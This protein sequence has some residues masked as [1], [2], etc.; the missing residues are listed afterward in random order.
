MEYAT[1]W[2]LGAL[3]PLYIAIF[4]SSFA[5]LAWIIPSLGVGSFAGRVSGAFPRRGMAGLCLFMALLLAA[6]WASLIARAEGG[7]QG[8]LLGQT[9]LVI[10]AY[11]L[12]LIVPL[13]VL[14]GVAALR[15]SGL[16]YFLCSVMVVKAAL[17]ASAIAAMLISAWMV[18]GKLE[19][20]PFLVF[21]LAA[22]ASVYLGVKMYSSVDP[23]EA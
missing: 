15:R 11:D 4:A 13:L 2:A 6:M 23:A 19:L 22:L 21:T 3:L 14:T 5:G 16:G 7:A 10:Q 18:E 9:T 1:Y 17:M 20:P 8:L 12:G